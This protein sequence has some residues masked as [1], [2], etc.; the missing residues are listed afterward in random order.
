MSIGKNAFATNDNAGAFDL[1][2]R[3]FGPRLQ[4]IWAVVNRMDLYNQ[5]AN[6]ILG[7]NG[8]RQNRAQAQD[9]QTNRHSLHDNS[10]VDMKRKEN[11]PHY[12]RKG[13]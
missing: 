6:G 5:V 1:S 7:I 4:K 9:K 3:A 8:R 10:S 11:R 13:G 2:R 12:I